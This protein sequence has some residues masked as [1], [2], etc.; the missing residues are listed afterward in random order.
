MKPTPG[1]AP[2]HIFQEKYHTFL[3]AF[4]LDCLL[5]QTEGC[6][7]QYLKSDVLHIYRQGII[8][9]SIQWFM[10]LQCKADWIEVTYM[11]KVGPVC[12]VSG[13]GRS[14]E[15]YHTG[16]VHV[17]AQLCV[18]IFSRLQVPAEQ[19]LKLLKTMLAHS[20]DTHFGH[21]DQQWDLLWNVLASASV[22]FRSAKQ[23]HLL[24]LH[25]SAD[26]RCAWIFRESQSS[27]H[28]SP[29]TDKITLPFGKK[30][31]AYICL[32]IPISLGRVLLP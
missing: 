4:L 17:D 6:R 9:C 18:F 12:E 10:T 31:V 27:C 28:S 23:S 14:P 30:N 1:T 21:L 8:E 16:P 24:Q 11:K 7:T 3:S 26:W 13:C 15:V 29:G 19:I 20:M 5:S 22:T 25:E 32:H 2:G